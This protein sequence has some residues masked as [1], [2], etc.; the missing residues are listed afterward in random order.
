M[1][2]P[3]PLSKTPLDLATQSVEP[4]IP[5]DT[6][7]AKASPRDP[8]PVRRGRFFALRREI[9]IWQSLLFAAM[10]IALVAGLWFAVTRGTG[11]ERIISPYALPS[12]EETF[13]YFYPEMWIGQELTRNTFA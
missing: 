12:P 11:E 3:K 9:P 1:S 5:A 8:T 4:A 6:V 10:F 7:V 13:D 2:D